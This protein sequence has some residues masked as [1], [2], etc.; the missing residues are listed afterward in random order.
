MVSDDE[1]ANLTVQPELCP[2]ERAELIIK[3]RREAKR[4]GIQLMSDEEVLDDPVMR[5]PKKRRRVVVSI[6]SSDDDSV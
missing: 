2:L 5:P 6:D 1:A 4:L 3:Q